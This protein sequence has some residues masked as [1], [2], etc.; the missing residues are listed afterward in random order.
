MGRAPDGALPNT[1]RRARGFGQSL[2]DPLPEADER[3]PEEP[4]PD[5]PGP[6]EPE[7]GPEFEPRPESSGSRGS[8]DP[9]DPDRSSRSSVVGVEGA[10]VVVG[11]VGVGPGAVSTVTGERSA[12]GTRTLAPSPEPV[13]A[14]ATP[15]ASTTAATTVA[16]VPAWRRRRARPRRGRSPA[17]TAS[18]SPAAGAAA[19]SRRCSSESAG[20]NPRSSSV[21]VRPP[22]P[23]RL[24]APRAGGTSRRLRST[25]SRPQ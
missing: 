10:V 5:E 23:S 1:P 2:L 12:G 25:S 4:V 22:F 18:A 20:S 3:D 17:N 24:R 6:E 19:C 7:P 14:Y 21:M 8:S 11:P 9:S 13:E 16:S 15:A